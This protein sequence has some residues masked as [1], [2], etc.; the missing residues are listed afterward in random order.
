MYI[1]DDR[2]KYSLLKKYGYI[3][4]NGAVIFSREK[5]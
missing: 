1:D 4:E 2:Y 3:V 5:I